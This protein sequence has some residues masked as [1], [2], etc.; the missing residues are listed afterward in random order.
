MYQAL[1]PEAVSAG[2]PRI[3][4]KPEPPGRHV[5]G[6]GSLWRGAGLFRAV[7]GDAPVPLPD[8]RYPQGHPDLAQ[9]L[10]ELGHLLQAQ[11]AYGEAR[12]YFKRHWR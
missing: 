12:G 1:Y 7:T 10:A 2:T 6:P 9:S 4:C 8:G 11:G 3:G 5:Q